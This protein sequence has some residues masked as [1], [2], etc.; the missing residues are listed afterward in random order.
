MDKNKNSSKEDN[1]IKIKL[2]DI[3]PSIKELKEQKG[4]IDIV[5]QGSDIFYNL[6][7][8]LSTKKEISLKTQKPAIIIS[9][10]KSTNIFATCLFNIKPGEQWINFSYGNKKKKDTTLAQNL[11]DC[12]K[13]KIKCVISRMIGNINS[14]NNTSTNTKKLKKNFPNNP[15]INYGSVLTENNNVKSQSILNQNFHKLNINSR[16]LTNKG[17]KRIS[18]E[19][20]PKEK[21]TKT[22]F[23]NLRNNNTINNNSNINKQNHVES[24]LNKKNDFYNEKKNTVEEKGLKR[25][26]TNTKNSYNRIIDDDL[27]LRLNKIMLNKND[28]SNLNLTQRTRKNLPSNYN[29]EYANKGNDNNLMYN[30][31]KSNKN[32]KNKQML[33]NKLLNNGNKKTEIKNVTSEYNI[34]KKIKKEIS[35][36]NFI[37]KSNN[38]DINYSKNRKSNNKKRVDR[39]HDYIESFNVEEKMGPM[40]NRRNKDILNDLKS[41][42]NKNAKTPDLSRSNKYKMK[43]YDKTIESEKFTTINGE[44]INKNKYIKDSPILRN[45]SSD[46]DSYSEDKNKNEDEISDNNSMYKS[47]NYSKLKEDFILL[48]SD[49]YVQNVQEDLLKLEIELFV[50]KMTGLISAY[51]Y[52]INEKKIENK[53]LEKNLKENSKNYIDFCKLYTKLNLIKKNH[54][55][56]HQR[57]QKNKSNIKEINDKNFETN[58]T[59]LEL[60]KLIFPNKENDKN[61][62]NNNI[63][64]IE[65]VDKREELK[66]IINILLTKEENKNIFI[67]TDLYTKWCDI[68][69]TECENNINKELDKD[70][71]KDI[72]EEKDLDKDLNKD[73]DIEKQIDNNLDNNLN[74]DLDKDLN[75]DKKIEKQIDDNSDNNL[76]ND[77]NKDLNNDKNIEKQIDNNSHNNLNNDINKDLNIDINKDL[78][79]D[80]N[81]DLNNDINKELNNDINKEL[82]KDLNKDMNKEMNKDINRSLDD[83]KYVKPKART[84]VIP[85]LQQTKFNSKNNNNAY[86]LNY[87]IMNNSRNIINSDKKE[88]TININNI[89]SKKEEAINY[90]NYSCLTLNSNT[91]VYSKNSA[92]YSLYPNKYYSKKLPK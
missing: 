14:N 89:N 12:I 54:K 8:L 53:I 20:S 40:T 18:L 76:N 84:R 42:I 88:Q 65:N 69:K 81:K 71:K 41:N 67:N 82:N 60:F 24:F 45:L 37:N 59:E 35:S 39:S 28:E 1:I 23:T 92:I 64:N 48:Y 11:I 47:D 62:N 16:L 6:I 63:D 38:Y 72:N 31:L 80:I 9:L 36:N 87:N 79:N 3:F 68:N 74:N 2:L 51:H 70:L 86:E 43:I 78:N 61:N 7:E 19:T 75:N 52:E 32:L 17:N 91:E 90:N 46:L 58:K 5:F 56:K 29:L 77:I 34:N 83:F 22:K 30:N 57:I 4:E 15:K 13:M 25:I 27:G 50:E 73:K 55:R 26:N 66:N 49:N 33:K 44:K 21:T 10:I 85:K